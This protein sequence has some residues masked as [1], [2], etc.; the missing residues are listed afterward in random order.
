MS[1]TAVSID[2]QDTLAA[3]LHRHFG[4]DHFRSGQREVIEA[5]LAGRS[6]VAIL[7]TGGGKSLCYQLT[8]LLSDGVTIVVSPLIALMKDQVD[9]LHARGILHSAEINS[10]LS[11]TEIEQRLQTLVAERLKL[12][13]VA[14]ERFAA[15]GFIELLKRVQVSLFVVDEAH[16]VSHWG[17]D[18][19]PDY[20]HLRNA[21]AATKPRA[22]L[23]LTATAT[24]AVRREIA[25]QLGLVDP[26]LLVNSFDRP[27]LFLG[28]V[29]CTAK[30]KAE[31]LIALA[32]GISGNCIVYVARQRDAEELAAQLNQHN[33]RAVPY[34]AG[35]EP[36]V[37]RANQQ[38]FIDGKARIIVA[39][40]AFGMGIDKPD[41]RAVIHY[42]HPG[43]LE[44]YYQE[45]GRAGRD[46]EPAQCL[47]L[48]DKRD[49]GIQRFFIEQRYPNAGEVRGIYQLLSQGV[50][51]REIAVRVSGLSE[52]K[53]NVA[54][55]LL[56]DQ[57]YIERAGQAVRL[58]TNKS[59]EDLRLDFSFLEQR[60]RADYRRLS[61]MLDYLTTESCRRAAI[62]RYF[63]ERVP[64][65]KNCGNCDLCRGVQPS[66]HL[67]PG[68]LDSRSI[69]LEAV[70]DLQKRGLGRSG[71]AQVLAGSQS[72]RMKQFQLDASPH[73]GKLSRLTQDQII[74]HIDGLISAGELR[75][76]PGQYPAVVLPLPTAK[77]KPTVPPPRSSASGL[78]TLNS[79]SQ[80]PSPPAQ[81]APAPHSV[82]PQSAIRNPQ[83][84][85]DP[86][87]TAVGWAILRVVQSQD[88]ELSRS[89]VVHF[90]R[91][92]IEVGSR[93]ASG[94]QT[95]P[96]FRFLAQYAHQ[97]LLRAVDLLIERKLLV[98]EA[99]E[100][101]HLWLTQ[102]GKAAMGVMKSD[103]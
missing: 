7:P 67:L 48:Y 25:L 24:P 65:G 93:R 92:T 12:L 50:P 80:I 64:V 90:L 77:P 98:V 29:P 44:A 61:E 103:E 26:F 69:I 27:N 37:R 62:L 21:I 41:V 34:H 97:D 13:Y 22:V 18:F 47:I 84:P 78:Q 20:L 33:I 55:T 99:S 35:L 38:A 82:N 32:Q 10:S 19:R 8:A 16:C 45:A 9:Q 71:L 75:L 17:H 3:A 72:R 101:L 31:A 51:P 66:D 30:A 49:S 5:V 81:S 1:D 36:G 94:N 56:Q 91:G 11:R 74:E 95:L 83:S 14:P 42:Q 86:V 100:H 54:L 87:P 57:G 102:K 40:V 28:V 96:G 53:V 4:F 39:T 15:P 2:P 6:T 46:G 70:R 85:F 52:E 68:V 60:Q 76:L 88:G 89:G 73:Y 79:Q 59:L 43:S 58:R 23:A 63:G